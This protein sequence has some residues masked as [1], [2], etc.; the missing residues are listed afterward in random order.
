MKRLIFKTAF[1]LLAVGLSAPLLQATEVD[2]KLEKEYSIDQN[3]VLLIRNRHG[4][5][6]F[7]NWDKDQVKIEVTITVEHTNERKA[8]DLLD[9]IDVEFDESGN[10]ISAIT[11][12]NDR[13]NTR[14]F[15]TNK[16]F[17]IDYTISHPAYLNVEV[18]NNYGNIFINEL[19]GHLMLIAKYTDVFIN[20]LSRGNTKP[21]NEIR[22]A[23]G[24]AEIEKLNWAIL[25]LSYADLTIN[26]ATALATESNYSDISFKNISSIIAESKYDD[27]DIRK[28]KNFIAE[29]G[30]TGFE[31]E[32]VS[33][34]VDIE[35]KYGGIS[36]DFVPKNFESIN[37]VAEYC[38]ASIGIE[39]GASY[40]LE[41]QSKYSR[42]SYPEEQ[43]T[44][45]QRII[46]NNSSTISGVV[47]PNKE[48]SR[49]VNITTRYG[50]IRLR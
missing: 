44:I 13:M 20:E 18:V 1:L 32:E 30:Y 40:K 10:E 45:F 22:L 47:G 31:I 16:D 4:D 27:W 2:K 28:V 50:G 48:T 5:V 37:I 19:S 17:D 29:G 41:A 9:L 46:E 39:D 14:F 26:E 21:V 6:K 23:Y 34:K 12:I 25:H 11:R 33:N 7:I 36:I 43:T 38:G 8:Q 15:G 49:M 24:D 3:S 35:T 42:I